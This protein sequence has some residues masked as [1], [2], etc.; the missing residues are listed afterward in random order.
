MGR[1]ILLSSGK[2]GAGK[3][4]LCANLATALA[5]FGKSVVAVDAN[6]TT[7][8][9]G[10]HLGIPLYPNT[11]QDVLKGEVRIKDAIYHHSAG[12][13]VLPADISLRELTAPRRN[14]LLGVFYSLAEGV[15][16]VLIDS[17]AGLG[18]ETKAA[19]EAADE[20]ITIT[21]PEISALTDALKLGQLAERSATQNLGVVV[22]RIK[23][24][25]Q[26]ISIREIEDFLDLPVLGEIEEDQYVRKAIANKEPVIL[27]KPETIS[28]RQMKS[29][30][31]KLIGE[32]Y[33][34]K[35]PLL[36][37]LFGWLR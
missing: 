23:K 37:R 19:L 16:F 1:I 21:N 12:F 17:S 18:E 35:R 7:S 13:R 24:E 10:L 34:V 29:V 33:Q 5:Q 20:V 4:T 26:E 2:G 8:N 11:L 14:D 31:A 28:S 36:D 22:N 27:H 25:E 9:L 15:D 30:A 32:E 3:T 6:V